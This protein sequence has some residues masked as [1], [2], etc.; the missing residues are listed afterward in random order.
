M[1]QSSGLRF[2]VYE[3]VHLPVD[4]ADIHELE[5]IELVPHI[6]VVNQGDQVLLRGNLL[7]SGIYGS[8]GEAANSRTLEH[9]IPV[10]IT[11]PM[12]RVRSLEDI[13]VEIDN[14]DVDLLSARTLN[15]TGVLSLTGVE[16]R[17]QAPPSYS[18]GA[19]PFT[20]VH[21]K[22]EALDQPYS[23]GEQNEAGLAPGMPAYQQQ[24]EPGGDKGYAAV[25]QPTATTEGTTEEAEDRPEPMSAADQNTARTQKDSLRQEHEERVEPVQWS[26]FSFASDRP[27]ADEASQSATWSP[28][29][30]RIEESE[31]YRQYRSGNEPGSWQG[32]GRSDADSS[33]APGDKSWPDAEDAS[34]EGSADDT[35]AGGALQEPVLEAAVE[36]EREQKPA[37]WN[38]WPEESPSKNEQQLESTADKSQD[39][40]ERTESVAEA[41][42][43]QPTAASDSQAFA[44]LQ[45]EFS[46]ASDAVPEEE[47][48]AVSGSSDVL[49]EAVTAKADMPETA[50]QPGNQQEKA[51]QEMKIALG[52]KRPEEVKAGSDSGY[53]SLLQSS[54]RD[55][56]ARQAEQDLANAAQAEEREAQPSEG[57]EIEWKKLFLSKSDGEREFRKVRMCIVQRE[58]TLE[59]IAGRYELHPRELQLYN[60]LEEQTVSEGQVLMI[61]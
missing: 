15:I 8:E 23:P 10:E 29:A 45:G 13:T 59:A 50:D 56:A 26:S 18:W 3:R 33:V 14:F 58:D 27:I 57:D 17:D 7:L 22:D 52:A 42:A 16:T 46:E 35:S 55:Q 37:A 19:E 32:A 2:D 41:S 9:W 28:D 20:V 43:V 53:S 21:T 51:K 39:E 12:N 60:R 31:A 6:Q 38:S 44:D 34:N 40:R 11:L 36:P 30:Y 1:N 24:D 48:A 61:P 25:E 54:R 47:G 5:E 4:V 49:T